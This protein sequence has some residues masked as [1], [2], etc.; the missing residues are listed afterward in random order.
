[1]CINKDVLLRVL[2]FVFV[3]LF[4]GSSRRKLFPFRFLYGSY[5]SLQTARHGFRTFQRIATN[6]VSASVFHV[7]NFSHDVV[8]TY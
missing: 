7:A 6:H 1:M 3:K 2:F 5:V 4:L 8:A